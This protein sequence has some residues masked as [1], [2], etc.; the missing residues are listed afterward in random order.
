MKDSGNNNN[1]TKTNISTYDNDI[2]CFF[3]D[4][5]NSQNL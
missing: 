1:K 2:K 5:K 3:K 4:N